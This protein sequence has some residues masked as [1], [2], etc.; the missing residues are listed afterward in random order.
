MPSL[1]IDTSTLRSPLPWVVLGICLVI[2]AFGVRDRVAQADKEGAARFD[3]HV[4][5]LE[6]GAVEGLLLVSG[7]WIGKEARDRPTGRACVRA[8][9]RPTLGSVLP[10][11]HARVLAS[12]LTGSK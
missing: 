1:H 9:A 7:G 4:A 10:S 3:E 11:R 6:G 5:N 2:T 8:R 12:T